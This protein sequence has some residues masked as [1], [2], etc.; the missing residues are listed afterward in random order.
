MS[1][2]GL[3]DIFYT[4]S[5]SHFLKL[6]LDCGPVIEQWYYCLEILDMDTE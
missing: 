3:L 4:T 6:L 1:I 2:W 5:F